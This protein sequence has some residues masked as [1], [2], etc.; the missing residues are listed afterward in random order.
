MITVENKFMK[1]ILVD[2]KLYKSE[3]RSPV[4]V[5]SMGVVKQS[6]IVF[7]LIQVIRSFIVV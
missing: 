5:L 7:I 3:N 1:L 4:R 2:V 6:Q